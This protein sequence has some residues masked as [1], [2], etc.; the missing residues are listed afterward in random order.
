[1]DEELAELAL[2]AAEAE[3]RRPSSTPP[4][5]AVSEFTPEAQLLSMAVNLLQV[6]VQQ[7]VGKKRIKFPPIPRPRTAVAVVKERRQRAYRRRLEDTL[8]KA[9]A[10]Y[11]AQQERLEQAGTPSEVPE[12]GHA[13]EQLIQDV[14]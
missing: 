1:M 11:E 4:T 3:G 2:D 9:H 8:A 5:V 6:Q 14:S 10:R 13:G 7:Q 12:A